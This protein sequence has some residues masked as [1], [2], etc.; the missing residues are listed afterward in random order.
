MIFPELFKEN[1]HGITDLERKV[2]RIANKMIDLGGFFQTIE[3]F[4]KLSTLFQDLSTWVSKNRIK[5]QKLKDLIT[6]FPNIK[7]AL[8][9][10]ENAIDFET[11]KTEGLC[12]VLFLAYI[13]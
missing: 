5:S 1:L 3:G 11:S 12:C 13:C 8:K 6:N 2:C 9:Y 10:F 7:E 4:Q